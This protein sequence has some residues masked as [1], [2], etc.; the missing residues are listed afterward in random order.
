MKQ[1]ETKFK[2]LFIIPLMM[3]MIWRIEKN[4]Q[5]SLFL[6]LTLQI[7]LSLSK[8]SLPSIFFNH[9]YRSI[10]FLLLLL[11]FFLLLSILIIVEQIFIFSWLS[12]S[13]L[14]LLLLMMIM[15]VN[16]NDHH[17]DHHQY[18]SFVVSMFFFIFIY[19]SWFFFSFDSL[20]YNDDVGSGGGDDG[21][22]LFRSSIPFIVVFYQWEIHS[23][24][25]FLSRISHSFF[26][27]KMKNLIVCLVRLFRFPKFCK[28]FFF[29]KWNEN[30]LSFSIA[31][32]QYS[33]IRTHSNTSFNGEISLKSIFP[34]F[35]F[36][37]CIW[38]TLFD[39]L[40]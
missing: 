39:L 32:Q 8:I 20:K 4:K 35:F 23:K 28:H 27:L 25:L 34:N 21:Q 40:Q 26:D 14:L 22:E 13:L 36:F 11:H 5:K 38:Q 9:C 30:I 2:S 1:N 24:W 29:W 16:R 33:K 6:S 31:L 3:M 17:H 12:L 15:V 10:D 7:S 37:I 18:N 19:L